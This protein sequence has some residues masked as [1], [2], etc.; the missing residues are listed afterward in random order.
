MEKLDYIF[1]GCLVAI[2]VLTV[3]LVVAMMLAAQEINTGLVDIAANLAMA[4]LDFVAA[5]K[6]KMAEGG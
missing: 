6:E 1:W 2:I 4:V 3:A 5:V